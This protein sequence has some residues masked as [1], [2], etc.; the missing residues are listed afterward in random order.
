MQGSTANWGGDKRRRRAETPD[1]RTSGGRASAPLY[2][3]VK[4]HILARIAS[5]EWSP[6]ARVSSEHEMVAA[7]GLSRMTVN[8]AVRELTADG[9]LVRVQGLGTF[10]ADRKPQ[11]TLLEIK[12]IADEIEAR[13]GQHSAEVHLLRSEPA[14]RPLAMLLDL[15]EGAP[16]FH[17]IVV[18]RENDVRIQLEDRYVNPA[19]APAYMAQDLTQTTASEYLLKV[20][21]L[22]EIEHVIEAVGPDAETAQLLEIDPAEP[23]LVLHRRTWSGRHVATRARFIHPGC[24]YRLGSRFKPPG[25]GTVSVA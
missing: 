18:H 17:S 19:V 21:P 6:G 12:S 11:S 22:T 16:V 7:L 1:I 8:R 10:V 14:A 2:Q 25:P 4:D 20:A 5:G 13:G 9:I 15:P 3:Q 24:R 23:C